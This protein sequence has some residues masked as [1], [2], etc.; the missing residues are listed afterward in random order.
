M[1]KQTEDSIV[2]RVGRGKS[3]T[4][5]A[6]KTLYLHPNPD[7]LSLINDNIPHYWEHSLRGNNKRLKKNIL[8]NPFKKEVAEEM[9]QT[10]RGTRRL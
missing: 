4:F 10:L 7:K 8:N 2:R 1:W 9:L 5:N 6:V 3:L